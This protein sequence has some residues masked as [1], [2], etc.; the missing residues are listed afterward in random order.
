VQFLSG[1]I[2]EG[3]VR[4]KVGSTTV[5]RH[6]SKVSLSNTGVIR[7]IPKD[8]ISLAIEAKVTAIVTSAGIDNGNTSIFILQLQ[9][10]KNLL[11]GSLA[12]LRVDSSNFS[13]IV[14]ETATTIELIGSFPLPFN[15]DWIV[16]TEI[17]RC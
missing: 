16:K 14:V 10:G 5:D 13:I 1:T 2:T 9:F 4:E 12:A 7:V 6:L 11:T 15:V 17:I 3:N 8:S